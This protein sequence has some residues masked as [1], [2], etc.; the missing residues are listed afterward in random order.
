MLKISSKSIGIYSAAVLVLFGLLLTVFCSVV[1]IKGDDRNYETVEATIVRI[2]E[3]YDTQLEQYTHTVFVDYEVD[4][5][6][7][8]D[9][10]YGAYDSSM[11]IGDKVTA[12]YD[13]EDPTLIQ[14]EG[15]ENVPYIVGGAGLVILA[16]GVYK[17]IE[18]I[19]ASE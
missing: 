14:A 13:T 7:Y 16:F 15:S 8:A 5:V 9:A 12:K 4:G 19:N 11:E 17:L 10:E 18:A 6:K 2:D 1:I 3:G